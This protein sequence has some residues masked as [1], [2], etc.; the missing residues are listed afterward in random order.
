MILSPPCRS[1]SRSFLRLPLS[2]SLSISNLLSSRLSFHSSTP[3]CEIDILRL[4]YDCQVAEHLKPLKSLLIVHG[5]FNHK[6][7]I[8]EFVRRCFD[9]GVPQLALS[10]FARIDKPSLSLQNLIVRCLCNDGLFEDVLSTHQ[11]CRISGCPSDNYTFPFVIKACSSLAA[12]RVGEAIHSVVLR[13]GFGENPVV[14]TAFVDLYAKCGRVE[15]ARSLLDRMPEP[16][17][18][19][20]NALI[21]GLSANGLDEEALDVFQ[22]IFQRGLKP[23]VSTLASTIP[24]CTRLGSIYLGKSLH[25]LAVKSGLFLDENLNL[26]SALISMYSSAGDLE[27]TRNLLDSP[28]EKNI[29]IWN[30]MIS[31]YTQNQKPSEAFMMIKQ[32]MQANLQPNMITFLAIIPAFEDLSLH[33]CVVKHGLAERLPIMTVLLSMYAKLGDLTAA[34]FLFSQ[35]PKRNVLS[36][37]SL[38][39]AYVQ[40]GYCNIGFTVFREMQ[41]TGFNPD[42]VSIVSVLSSCSELGAFLPGRSAHAYSIR[43]RFDLNLNVSNSLLAF[44]SNCNH[45]FSAFRIFHRMATRNVISWNTLISGCINNGEVTKAFS[46]LQHMRQEGINFDLVTL[47]SILPR[48]DGPEKLLE[49]MAI[50]GHVIRTGLFSDVSLANA[51][52]SMY[53]KC[54]ECESGRLIFEGMVNKSV[55]SWNALITGYRY[56]NLKADVMQFLRQMIKEDEKPNYIT[57][58]NV[59]PGCHSLLQGKSIHA[60]AARAGVMLE[61]SLLTSLIS[62]YARFK[63]INYCISL[64]ELEMKSNLSVWNAIISAHVHT[65]DP[66][67]A[68]VLFSRLLQMEIEPDYMTVLGL[69]SAC[70]QISNLNLT[71]SIMAYVIHKGFDKYVVVSNSLVDLYARCGDISAARKQFEGMPEKDA[72]SWTVM[73]NGYGLHGDGETALALFQKMEILGMKPQDITYISILSACSHAGLIEQGRNIFNS[74]LENR[75]LPRM[76]HYA[77]MVDLLGRRGNLDEAYGIVEQLPGKPS[78]SIL[79][80]LLGACINHGNYELG[81]EI[82][83]KLVEM[84]PQSPGAFVMLYNVLAAAGRWK[85]ANRVRSDME[86]RQLRKVPAISLIKDL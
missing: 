82:G 49:G 19:S 54:G 22:E 36:W 14:Q 84:E 15:I 63:S 9:L 51:L 70:V 10:T 78:V 45:L 24:V 74:M 71:N 17:L 11:K 4:L 8:G 21:S 29:S 7:L 32:I 69:V 73:I 39:S 79:E 81:E 48:Y 28:M 30:S 1:L 44:Y 67:K 40:N 20:W 18:I 57:L 61:A 85:E 42:G 27:I 65:K 6:L 2:Y 52:I 77:C 47:V 23:N 72:I 43:N 25:T 62:M 80:S 31:A 38:I 58:L 55:V 60:Y 86:A 26:T 53:F 13:S 56:H 12:L 37:N 50:H 33:A 75:V 5:V 34:E 83:R 35:M 68:V 76:E 3:P 46:L 59:L 41:V 64:F 16:D 66:E